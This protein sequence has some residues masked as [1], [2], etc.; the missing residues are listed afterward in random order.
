MVERNFARIVR[1]SRQR[2]TGKN[3][4]RLRHRVAA[5]NL[6]RLI[7]RQLQDATVRLCCLI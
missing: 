4:S 6:Q 5:L 2:G 1:D 7:T 3:Y